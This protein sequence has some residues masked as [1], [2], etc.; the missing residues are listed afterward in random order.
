MTFADNFV[1]VFGSNLSGIH[2]AGA[3]WSASKKYGAQWGLGIG[4]CGRAYAIP[5]KDED[6][7]T[8]PISE[9][10]K[11][12]QDFV[13]Y[14]AEHSSED[15]HVT[16]IGCGLAGFTARQIAPLF[17]EATPNVFFDLAWKSYLPNKNFWGTYDK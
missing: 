10:A 5:T 13:Q 8:L 6:I 9:V 14:A 1:F 3:A 7:N 4:R 12:V 11:H 15:F 2:G 17:T 16:Q